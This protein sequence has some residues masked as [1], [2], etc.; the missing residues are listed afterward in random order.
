MTTVAIS[1]FNTQLPWSTGDKENQ[2]FRRITYSALGATILAA[3][4]VGW[5]DLPPQTR[6]EKTKLPPQLARIIQAKTPPP[7]PV[8][9]PVKQPEKKPPPKVEKKPPPEPVKKP[10]V[11]E[12]APSPV[13]EKPKVDKEQQVKLARENA[14]KQGVLAFSDQLMAMRESVSVDNLAATEQ[15]K[16]AGQQA[17]TQR[18]VVG[19]KVSTT[20]QGL[21]QANLSSDIGSKGTLQGRKTTEFVAQEEGVAQLATKRI[22]S[23]SEVI[24]D[25][26]VESIRKTL[27]ANK[28]A[29]YSLYRRALRKDPGLQG[30]MTVSLVIEPDGSVSDVTLV[31]SELNAPELE[32]K[33]MARIKLISFQAQQVTQTTLEYAFNFLPF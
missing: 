24:G 16:G 18:K 14:S 21:S 11:V 3:V 15:I 6:E 17:Q 31:H 33:L 4:L 12:K 22:E 5:Q 28:G 7:P 9:E 25:R 2:L 29:I 32:K 13:V 10:V 27:D 8:V 26:D 1:A 30:K 23:A 20:S 19:R